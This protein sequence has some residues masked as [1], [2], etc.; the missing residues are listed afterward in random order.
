[1]KAQDYSKE[2]KSMLKNTF[3][4]DYRDY[5]F[6]GI[7]MSNFGVG[8]MYPAESAGRKFDVKTAGLYGDPNTWWA[9]T[10]SDNEKAA[11]SKL[12]FPSGKSGTVNLTGK[13]TKSL[14][15]S[16]VLPALSKL[17]SRTR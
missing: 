16:L 7:P 6:Y 10:M 1:M 17:L 3:A 11:E 14:S 13:K 12:I 8:T 15:L 2:M 9:T 5:Q 4:I